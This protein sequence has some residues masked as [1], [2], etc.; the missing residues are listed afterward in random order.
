MPRT[1]APVAHRSPGIPRSRGRPSPTPLVLPLSPGG[2]AFLIEVLHVGVQ[3]VEALAPEPLEPTGPLVDRSQPTRVE[4]V[5]AL[6][7]R[8]AIVYQPH[9]PEYPQVLGRPWL[10]HTQLSRDV[11]DRPLAAPQQHQDVPALRLGNRVEDVRRGR[12]PCHRRTSYSYT[13]MCQAVRSRRVDRLQ[14]EHAARQAG[15]QGKRLGTERL[16]G[17]VV[18]LRIRQRGSGSI[19]NGGIGCSKGLTQTGRSCRG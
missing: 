12:C 9:L 11:S 15:M 19:G 13:S 4:P 1:P 5:E 7:A 16:G 18:A 17:K 8:S 10:S 14:P 6:L 2:P 3:P